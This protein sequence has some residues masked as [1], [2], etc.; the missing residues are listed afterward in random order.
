MGRNPGTRIG[1]TRGHQFSL[2]N[3]T[4]NKNK[5]E[6]TNAHELQLLYTATSSSKSYLLDSGATCHVTNDD[7]DLFNVKPDRTKIIVGKSSTCK[8]KVSGD[9]HISIR[10]MP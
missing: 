5:N 9:L 7:A 10:G 1:N 4:E 2:Q 6:Y 3:Q 8:A